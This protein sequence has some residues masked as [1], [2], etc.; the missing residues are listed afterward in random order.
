VQVTP[1]DDHT[2]TVEIIANRAVLPRE[3]LLVRVR[4]DDQAGIPSQVKRSD[5]V[6]IEPIDPMRP[7]SRVVVPDVHVQ[8][9]DRGRGVHLKEAKFRLTFTQGT[10]VAGPA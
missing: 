5:R 8:Y 7:I 3:V 4:C 1:E 6:A 10:Y 2:A 9:G